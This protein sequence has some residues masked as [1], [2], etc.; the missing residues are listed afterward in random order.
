MPTNPPSGIQR[1]TTRIAYDDPRAAM[2][3][4]E[5]AFGF[6]EREDKRLEGANG[7]IIVAEVAIGE[8]YLMIGPSGAHSMDSPKT[9]GKPTESLMV[10]VD[11]IDE[12]FERARAEG[13]TI[14]AEPSHQY[15]GDRRY[16][17]KDPEGHL[18]FFHERTRDVPRSEID[19][20]EATFREG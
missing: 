8:A 20:I 12:H 15:W 14:I 5:R 19:A 18:W 9:T 1:L 17:A 3:F 11:N 16:E 10:Y 13:A 4:L 6:P 7:S 2:E